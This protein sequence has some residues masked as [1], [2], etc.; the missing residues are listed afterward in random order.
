MIRVS[1]AAEMAGCSAEHILQMLRYGQFKFRNI[2]KPNAKRPTY[3]ID[4]RTFKDWLDARDGKF[5]T[6]EAQ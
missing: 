2:A 3:R 5:K 6:T 1:K 4:L